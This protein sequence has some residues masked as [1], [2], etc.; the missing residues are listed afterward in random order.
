MPAP[1]PTLFEKARERWS[2]EIRELTDFR[3]LSDITQLEGAL[4]DLTHA[5]PSG[6]AQLYAG[7]PTRLS[8][9]VRETSALGTA[10]RNAAEMIN[11]A[12]DFVERF[13]TA[14]I[15]LV[16]GIGHWADI[17]RSMSSPGAGEVRLV[18]APLLMRPVQIRELEESD[19]ELQL[20]PG[21]E[22]NPEFVSALRNAGFTPDVEALAAMSVTEYGFSPRAALTQLGTL[23][24]GHLADFEL[25]EKIYTGPFVHPGKVLLDDIEAAAAHWE[26]HPVISALAGD[27][28]VKRRLAVELP[29]RQATDRAPDSER[30]VGDLDP[31]QQAIL[32]HVV[33]GHNLILDARPGADV[34]SMVSAILADAAGSGRSVAYVSGTRRAGRAVAAELAELGL[35][36]LVLDLQDPQWRSNAPVRLRMGLEPLDPEVDDAVIRATR[37]TLLDVRSQLETYA[38]ALHTAREPWGITAY[39]A[40]QNLA[41]LTSGPDAPRTPVRFDE[42]AIQ[43]LSPD[44]RRDAVEKLARLSKLGAFTLRPHDTPW[45]GARILTSSAATD[46]LEATQMLGDMVLPRVLSDVG[47]V[48]RETGLERAV[49]MRDWWEQI[50]MLKGIRESLDI[51]TPVIFERSA[52]DMVIATASAQWRKEK[53]VE[54]PSSVRRRLTKQARDLVRPGST[55]DDLHASLVTVQKQ[56]EVWRRHCPAGGW[57]RLPHALGD[58]ERT[59]S[60]ARA[61]LDRLNGVFSEDLLALPLEELKAKMS[62]L[63]A[64]PAALRYLPEVNTIAEE[65]AALGLGDLV[66]DLSE[67]RIGESEVA[68]EL[69]LAWWASVLESIVRSDPALAG[70]DGATLNE[71]SGQFRALDRAHV[72]TLAG[73]IRRAVV[74]RRARAI[75]EDKRAAQDLWRELARGHAA[76]LRSLRARYGGLVTASRPI[77]TLPAML[78]GQVLP[79]ERTIDVLVVDGAQHLP[80]AAVVGAI[81]RARQVV[82]VGDLSR[83][84]TGVVDELTGTLPSVELPRDRG[85]REEHIAAFLAGHGYGDVE[86]SVPAR[87]SPARIRLHLVEGYGMPALG[88]VSVEGVDA[89]VDRVLE[90]AREHAAAG[91]SIAIISLSTVTAKRIAHAV[92]ADEGLADRE[93]T[94]VEV[95]NSAGLV[96]DTVILSVG[97]AKTPHGRVLHRFG[98]VSTPEGLSLMIDA[99]DVPRHNLDIVSCVAPDDLDRDRLSHAG[100]ELLADLLD[101]ASDSPARPGSSKVKSQPVE[102]TAD[103]LL[104]DLGQ[105]LIERGLSVA[106][107]YGYEGGVRLPLA[108]GHADLPGEYAV[109]VMTDDARYVAEPS[110]RRRDRLRVERLERH[111]WTVR[112]AFS[113]A[114]FMDPV[115]EAGAIEQKV[116]ELLDQLPPAPDSGI[117]ER[118]QGSPEGGPPAPPAEGPFSPLAG[119]TQEV[120]TPGP[121]PSPV[122]RSRRRSG[123]LSDAE[124]GQ[125][126]GDSGASP[127]SADRAESTAG[128]PDSLGG[129]LPATPE[130]AS[131]TEDAGD[132][133]SPD[134]SLG[135]FLVD[136]FAPET[137]GG[138][139]GGAE[140]DPAAPARAALTRDGEGPGAE[141]AAFGL[142][143]ENG[144]SESAPPLFDAPAS[145]DSTDPAPVV[146]HGDSDAS[147][148]PA[149]DAGADDVPAVESS[150]T[151]AALDSPPPPPAQGW[152]FPPVRPVRDLRSYSDDELDEIARECFVDGMTED[153]LIQALRTR[154]QVT[155]RGTRI[156]S[157]LRAVA[158]RQ[159]GR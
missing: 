60:E 31:T 110:L 156:D 15:Y 103:R 42:A 44:V 57:P 77:W 150:A 39:D 73:P 148:P 137:L 124:P 149:D 144:R 115:G 1:D 118:R 130:S 126:A 8:N 92:E 43:R 129:A 18:N 151:S 40:L 97:F 98:P 71:L 87:P 3:S 82:L 88:A 38:G 155:R 138:D 65:L 113:T 72:D 27:L 23:G 81:S 95:E 83:P 25:E 45:Y 135:G 54:M 10:R 100:A 79:P 105:R 16:I 9:L 153:E 106:H 157:T 28:E 17:A 91:E 114:V 64:D 53:A 111:G 14:P 131:R 143:A 134:E 26:T 136:G 94:V 67:R 48:T 75:A 22:I 29:E 6:I 96:K 12:G 62:A 128:V 68:A 86:N 90:L 33:A 66:G 125:S 52:A 24:A 80:T 58:A 142:D 5:H 152:L 49:S 36:E 122:E 61:L 56:R 141:T 50:E 35:G 59:A 41:D 140:S 123:A 32:D 70:Y 119:E 19:V 34:P 89:E 69:E 127:R 93:I 84:S 30:G 2:S 46:A 20:E 154:I 85:Q 109:A 112:M 107:S 145:W 120:E 7:R 99:L 63:G 117:T 159:L 158:A 55:A 13:G 47:R 102:G 11:R 146:D 139:E 78:V 76:D 147:G 121:I 51:F 104:A 74:R 37:T 108:V 133:A 101:F 132:A 4:I 116:R 21:I